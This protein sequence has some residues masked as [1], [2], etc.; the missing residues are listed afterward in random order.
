MGNV[1]SFERSMFLGLLF[2]ALLE[3]CGDGSSSAG[4]HSD[5]A[6]KPASTAAIVLEAAADSATAIHMSWAVFGAVGA[7]YRIYRDGELVDTASDDSGKTRDTGLTPG[8]R[9]CYRVTAVDAAGAD[10]ADSNQSC[11]TT[12]SLA[13]WDIQ[14]IAAAPPVSL[15]LDAQG[16]DR[17]SFCG[18]KG[19]YYQAR[20]ADGSFITTFLDPA[21]TCFG[22]LL[23]VGGDGSDHIVYA[24]THSDQLKYATDVSGGWVVRVIPGADGAEFPSIGLDSGDAVHVAYLVFTG[25]SPDSYQLDYASNASV[26]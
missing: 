15:A 19:V 10:I 20:Q 8:S 25:H 26:S 7:G 1:P 13:S 16:L 12:A 22:A 6:T 14:R 3:G 17:I 11:A 18:P 21:A 24:D 9:Y 4:S 2:T 5:T 23:V